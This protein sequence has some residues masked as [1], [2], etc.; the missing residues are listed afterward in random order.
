MIPFK[1][2]SGPWGGPVKFGKIVIA[3]WD[4][5]PKIPAKAHQN[6]RSVGAATSTLAAY[7]QVCPVAVYWT[8]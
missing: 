2:V 1:G 7:L 3:P 6:H 8:H 5:T 4:F